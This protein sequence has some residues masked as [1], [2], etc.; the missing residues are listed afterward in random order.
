MGELASS[1]EAGGCGGGLEA[2]VPGVSPQLELRRASKTDFEAVLELACQLADHIQ[3][4]RPPLTL[5]RF[6]EFYLRPGAPMQLVLAVESYR[7]VG[8]ISWTITHELYSAE[9]RLY[10]SDLV[11]SSTARGHGIG[12]ALMNE[13]AASACAQG[14]HKLGWEVWRFNETARR[15]Y[16]K[17]GGHLDEEALPYVLSLKETES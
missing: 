5:Q 4:P 14:V 6:E 12:R 17:F 3:S 8:M 9:A 2:W 1:H 7:V 16:E 11:V 13:V 15:F 10:I